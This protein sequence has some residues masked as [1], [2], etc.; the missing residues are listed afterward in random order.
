MP[1]GLFHGEVAGFHGGFVGVDVFFVISGYLITT[2][3]MDDLAAGWFSLWHF[4]ERRARR[5]L[6]ALMFVVL[7]SLPFAWMWFLPDA[8]EFGQSLA[9]G[10][11][12][13]TA[14]S[15]ATFAS[16]ARAA[17]A[18]APNPGLGFECVED[19]M[20]LDP[21]CRTGDMPRTVLWGDSYAMHLAQALRDSLDAA[22]FVQH[23]MSSCAPIDTLAIRIADVRW[24]DCRAI[25]A[26]AEDWVVNTV[27]IDTMILGAAFLAFEYPAFDADGGRLARQGLALRLVEGL[28]ARVDRLRAAGKRVVL[29]APPPENGQSLGRCVIRQKMVGVSISACDFDLG[30]TTPRNRAIADMLGQLGESLPVL[31]LAR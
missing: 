26:A 29:V 28:G 18:F 25:N 14:P 7:C 8:A 10:V 30:Q 4:Y 23:T 11:P 16:L 27:M 9:E 3:L 6:P 22:P 1:V 21:A 15:G 24:Q 13:R 19:R 12:Q 2:I 31:D 20:T 5:I 17:Q